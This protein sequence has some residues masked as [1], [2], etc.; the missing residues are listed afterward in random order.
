MPHLGIEFVADAVD[1]EEVFGFGAVVAKLFSQLHDD[2]VEG[3]RGAI[4]VLAPDFVEEAVARKDFAGM[5]AKKLEE[6]QFAGSQFLDGFAAANLKS[7][8]IDGGVAD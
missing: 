6:F 1:S 3:A 7:F 4:V 5:G 2:L 8:R